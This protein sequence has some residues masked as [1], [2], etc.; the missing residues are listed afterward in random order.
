VS[1]QDIIA[2]PFFVGGGGVVT[3]ERSPKRRMN[4]QAGKVS[5]A[6]KGIPSLDILVNSAAL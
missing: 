5:L 6:S 4:P 1:G 2:C 3:R